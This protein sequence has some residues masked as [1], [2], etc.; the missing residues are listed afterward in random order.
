MEGNENGEYIL[1]FEISCEV[2]MMVDHI[3]DPTDDTQAVCAYDYYADAKRAQYYDLF[4][5]SSDRD[6]PGIEDFF[7]ITDWQN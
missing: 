7:N 3:T 4:A 5:R 1:R 2:T 6:Y